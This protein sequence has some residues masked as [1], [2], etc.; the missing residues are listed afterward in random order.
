MKA[1][2]SVALAAT[3]PNALAAFNRCEAAKAG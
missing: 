1:S 2:A 3:A